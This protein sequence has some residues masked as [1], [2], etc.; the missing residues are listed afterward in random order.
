MLLYFLLN[1]CNLNN[2]DTDTISYVFSWS[3]DDSCGCQSTSKEESHFWY[4][5]GGCTLLLVFFIS[6]IIFIFKKRKTREKYQSL[7]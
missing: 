2:T 3:I 1:L 6:T 5:F 7:V 4:V